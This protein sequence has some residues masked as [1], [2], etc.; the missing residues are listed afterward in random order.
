MVA[1][2]RGQLSRVRQLINDGVSTLED[3][4]EVHIPIV[5]VWNVSPQMYI[6]VQFLKCRPGGVN[7]VEVNNTKFKGGSGLVPNGVPITDRSAFILLHYP[8]KWNSP[9]NL[10]PCSP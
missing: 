3:C 8:S 2:G 9:I 1:A 5:M 10:A 7:E 6:I 4:D